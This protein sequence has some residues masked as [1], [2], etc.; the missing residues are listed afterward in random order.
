MFVSL[1]ALSGNY[2]DVYPEYAQ[3]LIN[4]L[5]VGDTIFL[6][7]NCFNSSVTRLDE[8]RYVQTTP[9]IASIGKR[10]GKRSVIKLSTNC[11]SLA[12]YQQ[13]NTHWTFFG[14]NQP[15]KVLLI[16]ESLRHPSSNVVWQWS[17][18]VS[19]L[20][21][22]QEMD[23]ISYSQDVCDNI[24]TAFNNN[25]SDVSVNIGMK[26]YEIKFLLDDDRNHSTFGKQCDYNKERWIRRAMR[27]F[28]HFNTPAN[29]ESCA[30]CLEFFSD[31]RHMPWVKTS[32][33]HVF[34]AVCL[35]RI[36]DRC[37]LCRTPF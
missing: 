1:E 3:N 7:A 27:D 26:Q 31:T 36:R 29:E 14:S 28:T 11:T 5:Q 4:S 20:H 34:H 23:W 35:D 6:G 18:K 8:I 30:L 15:S 24:E 10:S 2:I 25:N 9:S 16:S 22:I 37:P 32:C 13:N 19:A 21:R 17:C 12:V 33:N